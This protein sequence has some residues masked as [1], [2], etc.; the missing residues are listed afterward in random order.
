MENTNQIPEV[1]EKLIKKAQEINFE[2]GT[3]YLVGELLQTLAA[4]KPNGHF[5]ELGTGIGLS[6]T[7]IYEGMD[8]QSRL[9]SIDND[10]KLMDIVTQVFETETRIE[11]ITTDGSS[12]IRNRKGPKFD[13]IFADA[14]PEK[15]SDLDHTLKLLNPGGFYVIDDMLPQPNWPK[16]HDLKVNQLMQDLKSKA[17]FKMTVMNW[18]TG[19]MIL[20]KTK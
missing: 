12:W 11:F 2:M 7:W 19:V 10:P 9:I 20:T 13:L 17:G 18:S 5:L 6:T 16:G 15:Y 14:W 3:D 8:E 4:S 1:L